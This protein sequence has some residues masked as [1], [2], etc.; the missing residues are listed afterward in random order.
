MEENNGERSMR[1]DALYNLDE[2][3]A[4]FSRCLA[5]DLRGSGNEG[6]GEA[7]QAALAPW[8][9]GPTPVRIGYRCPVANVDIDLGPSWRIH[10]SGELLSRLRQVPG[11]EAVSLE[12][13]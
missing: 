7:L 13:Q 4:R 2:A 8:R 5:I 3:R 11:T 10:P 1:V 9:N 12:Y 6:V